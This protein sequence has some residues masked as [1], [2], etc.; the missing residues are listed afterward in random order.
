LPGAAAG[1]FTILDYNGSV[2][3][4]TGT[5]LPDPT[6][7]FFLAS[8]IVGGFSLS[9]VNNT[10]NTSLDLVVT[11]GAVAS[12]TWNVDANGNWST[13]SNWT[14]GSAPNSV[15]A[16]ANFGTIIT[17]ARTVTVDSPQTVGT[18]NFSSSNSYTIA[19]SSTLTLDVGSGQAAINVTAGSHTISAPLVLNDNTTITS[20]AGTG[21]NLSG[22]LTATGKTITK[23]GAG[24]VQLVNV[25]A[26]GLTV[27]EGSAKISAKGTPNSPAGTSV[28]NSLTIANGASL[29]LTNNSA[30]I[31]Y[32]GT[33]GTLVTTTRQNLQS[34]RLTSSAADATKKLGYGD[35]AVLNKAT[36]A[37][38]TVDA[39]SI[40]IKFTYGGDANLDGQV[41]VTD[42]GSLA[43]NWQ[44]SAPWTGG[45]FD[46]SGFVDVTDLGILATNWQA[47]VGSPLGR[48][49]LQDALAEVGLGG[50]S[51]PE[52]TSVGMIVLAAWSFSRRR[53]GA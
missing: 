39:S 44:T 26:A 1:T 23:A 49:S 42:L 28:V 20:A 10:A 4:N 11:G 46:Y 34:G 43:T 2:L 3:D 47:G 15:D 33:V 19:G 21:V 40:L 31:D 45:D 8:S 27:N 25:R 13:G 35:N 38:Q 18:A 12:A 7:R 48:Q 17:A 14:G 9:L 32:T 29:D 16:T 30:V 6:T 36:F 5:A 24:T 51:V 50:V 53:R 37:G 52:P 41:D 22:N